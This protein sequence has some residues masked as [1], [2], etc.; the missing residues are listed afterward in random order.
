MYDSKNQNRILQE[1]YTKYKRDIQN[2]RMFL[3]KIN[4]LFTDEFEE[5]IEDIL[6]LNESQ[7]MLQ[8][9]KRVE[10][11]LEEIYSNKCFTEKKFTNL[12]DKGLDTIKSEYKS[13]Y[14]ILDENYN[15]YSKNRTSRRNNI[16]FLTNGYRRHCI[17]EVY[18]AYCT[19]NCNYRTGK[20]LKVKKKWKR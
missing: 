1:K 8:L 10:T 2:E 18:N 5:L 9:K 14:E 4:H 16:E 13:N 3:F 11:E 15:L 17:K 6:I 7:F 12:L 20:F 19:H